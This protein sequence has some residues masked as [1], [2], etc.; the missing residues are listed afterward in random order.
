[1]CDDDLWVWHLFVGAPGSLNDINVMQQSPLYLDVTGGRWPPRGTPCTINGR[2][3][4]LP[5]YLVDG[6]YPRYTFLM[7][8]HP[9][10]SSEEQKTFKRLQEAIRKD[11]ERL[12]GVLMKRFHV[13]L[14]PGRYRSVSQ[15]VTT[16]S[17]STKNLALGRH[18]KCVPYVPGFLQARLKLS[19]VSQKKSQTHF[20]AQ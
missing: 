3:R 5:Y 13:A 6:I 11:V 8:P 2:T 16:Y 19:N 17:R 15:L 18:Q 9:K 1:L 4:T 14:H 10:P 20:C 12:F 7:S